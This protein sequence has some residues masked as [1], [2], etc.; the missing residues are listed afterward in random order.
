MV[1]SHYAFFF[2]IC[3]KQKNGFD[4]VHFMQHPIETILQFAANA[5]GHANID[6]SVNGRL[7]RKAH[8]NNKW[9]A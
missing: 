7:K 6:A 3:I 1:D 8:L 5:N 9:F 4:S 2:I